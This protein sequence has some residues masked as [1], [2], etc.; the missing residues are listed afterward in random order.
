MNKISIK[1]TDQDITYR[2]VNKTHTFEVNDK[3]V[4]V[5]TVEGTDDMD[6]KYPEVDNEDIKELTDEEHE[7]FGEELDNYLAL[8]VGESLEV[9]GWDNKE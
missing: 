4:R 9:N 6:I 7:I 5:Y 8:K 3:E 2:L 1:K